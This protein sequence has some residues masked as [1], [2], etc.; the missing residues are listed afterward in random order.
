M[1]EIIIKNIAS[2]T[3]PFQ[4]VTM[5]NVNLEYPA[6]ICKHIHKQCKNKVFNA[7]YRK[8]VVELSDY[9]LKKL[10]P[11]ATKEYEFRL[12][13][14]FPFNPYFLES[15]YV[16]KYLNYPIISL[17]MDKYEFTGGAHGMTFRDSQTWNLT[18]GK[19]LSLS[20]LFKKN[21]SFKKNILAEIKKQA[22]RREES[23][24]DIY[25]DQLDESIERYFDSKN[26]YLT[27]QGIV[28]YYPLYTIAPYSEGIQEFLIPYKMFKGNTLYRLG[29][30]IWDK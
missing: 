18:Y 23:K 16:V 13:E 21:Y 4:D 2:Y 3:I 25:F 28:I 5:L 7:Y 11:S 14:E 20:Q 10:Y 1:K 30:T 17:Y 6:I 12:E 22:H 9:A 8:R 29:K 26:F 24:A 15:N 19:K 27:K